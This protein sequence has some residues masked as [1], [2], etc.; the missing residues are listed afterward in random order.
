MNNKKTVK[1]LKIAINNLIIEEKKK[2]QTLKKISKKYILYGT[3]LAILI[4]SLIILLIVVTGISCIKIDSQETS[5]G[6]KVIK[7]QI[8]LYNNTTELTDHNHIN[9]YYEKLNISDKK[10]LEQDMKLLVDAETKHRT[11]IENNLNRKGN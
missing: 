3:R 2:R 4:C 10:T 1:E 6:R 11:R 9:K 5:V 8:K 7:E